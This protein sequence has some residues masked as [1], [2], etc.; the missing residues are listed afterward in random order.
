LLKVKGVKSASQAIVENL[1]GGILSLS[2]SL[3]LSLKS[4]F[5]FFPQVT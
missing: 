5:V 3:S 1:G 2:L 4:V